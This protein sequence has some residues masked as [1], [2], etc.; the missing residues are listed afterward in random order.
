MEFNRRDLVQRLNEGQ[1]GQVLFRPGF[2][3]A[4]LGRVRRVYSDVDGTLTPVCV[5]G[6]T[7]RTE[8]VLAGIQRVLSLNLITGRS[9]GQMTTLYENVANRDL[10]LR[11]LS[12]NGGFEQTLTDG[13]EAINHN[14]ATARIESEVA[15]IREA[16]M[17]A[18]APDGI[19]F[20]KA[21][22]GKHRC[23][24]SIDIVTADC[25]EEIHPSERA[26]YMVTDQMVLT[27]LAQRFNNALEFASIKGWEVENLR[28][29]NFGFIRTEINKANALI[30][31]GIEASSLSM[32][33]GDSGND[34]PMFDLRDQ[35]PD[36]IV[37]CTV[38][39][40]ST[41]Q[42]LLDQSDIVVVGPGMG[43]EV[44]SM[45]HSGKLELAA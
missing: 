17:N 3:T 10:T 32:V 22:D 24:F 45:V 31:D 14:L 15:A 38:F 29:G 30:Q 40:L 33:L 11:T 20:L 28:N 34:Q 13:Q 26:P 27:G 5:D 18:E 6:F 36:Q 43:A 39:G 42:S 23:M 25:P 19:K 16:I 21:G 35:F 7:E 1:N 44:L 4:Q 12:E 9:T 41:P 37:C 8:E 2:D